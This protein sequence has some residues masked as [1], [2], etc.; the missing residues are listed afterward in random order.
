MKLR[1]SLGQHM[2]VDRRVIS[3]IVGYAELSE[4]DVVLE[5]GCGTGNLTSAL[6][7]KCSVVGI[8]KDPLMVKRLR[9][10]FSDFIGKGRFR[11]IQGDALKVDFPYFTKFVAN[12]P[13]KISSPLTFKLLKTDFRLAVVMY[14]REFAERLCGEDN[15][16]GVISKTYCKAEILE[17]VKP[18]SFNP[19]PKV[20]SAIV[21]IVPEPEV[22]VENRE[23]FEKFVTFAFSMRRKRMGKIVQEFRK[24]Y[25]VELAVNKNLAEKR[26]EEL[27]ARKFAEI[28]VGE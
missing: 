19:P 21:R 17:I 7:R 9:E 12:I 22:F 16:L 23:L 8:E 11:L 15:R 20:E 3:R 4:D 5:V 13:Y 10:R 27:G 28:V 24:R 6:L 1:K 2:L 25:G 18:S 14:Q 26:P